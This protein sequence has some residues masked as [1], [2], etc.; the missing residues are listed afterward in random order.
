[1]ALQHSHGMP[2]GTPAPAF[3]LPGTDGAVHS[4]D[5]FADAKVLVVV[6]TCNH[7]P[8]A[9]ACE[10]RLVDIQRD[11]ADRGVQL[12]AINPN[13]ATRYP[14][15]NFDAMKVRAAEKG[16]NFPY[17]RDESQEVARAYDA[18]CTPDPFVFDADRKLVYSGRI[19]DNWKD[20]SAVT[21]KDL[22]A[23]ID[24]TLAGQASPLPEAVPSM[25]CSIK[26][27]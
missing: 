17:L 13:D 11:Y 5:D 25:G 3:S 9:I 18:A 1:M 21:H 27:K 22:R 20:P 19:D 6:F 14:A 2:V 16:F 24:A 4:L 23:V 12:V 26:W 7:C 10:D 8:Y 15:D